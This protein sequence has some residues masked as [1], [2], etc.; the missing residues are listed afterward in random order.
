MELHWIAFT[1]RGCRLALR[2]AQKLG[3]TVVRGGGSIKAAGWTR[4]HFDA[5]GLIFVG[6]V[7]IAVRAAAPC[8][9]GKQADPAIVVIDE[10]A[11]WAI[12]V[13]SG[14]LGGA[15]RLAQRIA[16]LSGAA[17]VITTATDGRGLFAAD[18]WA[19]A[20]GLRV[21]NPGGIK[22]ISAA[23][24]AGKT[25]TVWSR[26]PVDG[27]CPE[28]LILIPDREKAALLIDQTPPAEG[29]NALWLCPPLQLGVGCRRGT[30]AAAIEQALLRT[31]LQPECIAGVSSIDIKQQE[32]GLLAFCRIWG[33]TLQTYTA[34]QLASVEG[35]LSHSVFVQRTVG[36]DNVCER[37]ALLSAG[38]GSVLAMTK[39]AGGGVALAAALQPPR[40]DWRSE[41]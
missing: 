35:Q 38:S 20:Q 32:P 30:E 39:Q 13:L 15:N 6:A 14:H 8:L 17:A 31:G 10:N 21:V 29:Q 22:R 19:K 23:L 9:K 12:P 34:G 4:E 37:A 18:S 36:V 40:L 24:L 5:D 27:E 25:V 7:G 11:R 16:E 1:D 26:W 41:K 3:G 28:G 2:L 33:L